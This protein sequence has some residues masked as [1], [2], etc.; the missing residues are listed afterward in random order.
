MKTI[1]SKGF[2]APMAVMIL[3]GAGAFVTTSMGTTEALVEKPGYHFVNEEN[4]CQ[5][6]NER[7]TTDQ[8][9]VIC[10]YNGDQLYGKINEESPDNCMLPLRK[11][12]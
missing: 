2:V 10:T 12:L 6:E 11:V 4:P 8:T 5:L 3:G 1:F 9:G 7:C